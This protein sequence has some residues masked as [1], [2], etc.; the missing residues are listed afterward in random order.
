[1]SR[2]RIPSNR[3][4]P[5][6]L[7]IAVFF[8]TP[9]Y[10]QQ[11]KFEQLDINLD[12]NLF[13]N[14]EWGALD[15]TYIG[16]ETIMYLNLNVQE[17][18]QIQNAPIMSSEG[19]GVE[20]TLTFYFDLG[21]SRGDDVTMVMFTYSFT[22][23]P[24]PD[25]PLGYF[26]AAPVADGRLIRY[27]GVEAGGQGELEDAGPMQGG[28]ADAVERTRHDPNSS[29]NQE[30]DPNECTPTAVSN[31]L[32]FLNQD[33]GLGLENIDPEDMK[34]AVGWNNEGGAPDNWPELKDA[35]MK[36][37]G[38]PI[39]T[40]ETADMSELADEINKKKQDV[41]ISI[42]W[43]IV[44]TE[45]D[46]PVSRLESYA[47][48]MCV[49]DCIPIVDADGNVTGYTLVLADDREQGEAGGLKVVEAKYDCHDNR[50]LIPGY[51]HAN[52]KRAVIE[53]PDPDW[54]GENNTAGDGTA[55]VD[56]EYDITGPDDPR[57]PTQNTDPPHNRGTSTLTVTP[58]GADDYYDHQYQLVVQNNEDENKIKKVWLQ[59]T[60]SPDGRGI[61]H[62]NLRNFHAS[63]TGRWYL[64]GRKRTLLDDGDILYTLEWVIDPQPESETFYWQTLGNTY[65]KNIKVKTDCVD[66]PSDC[67]KDIAKGNRIP[68][69]NNC[70]CKVD[71]LDLAIL[72]EHWLEDRNIDKEK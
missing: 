18:W 6:A 5:V 9:L 57:T 22:T 1:M 44:F 24:L 54:A 35:Y 30:S 66:K 15:F 33:R 14:T 58:G 51:R 26:F 19:V 10:A 31:S 7:V 72:A 43:Q 36:K 32:K 29:P 11:L 23:E 64:K 67:E 13:E 4:A 50:L 48:T 39:K 62:P 42:E 34:E 16:Q 53:C 70:D 47:H 56:Q 37:H 17:S 63:P 27:I 25:I 46:P 28:Q 20:Q 68:G 71:L 2:N 45:G 41:E 65:I 3:M 59:Y 49:L 55:D 21:N 40:R 69:D 52:F 61:I 38:I 8:L 12:G 60:Y